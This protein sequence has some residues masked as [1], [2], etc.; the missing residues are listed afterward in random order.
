MKITERKERFEAS[1]HY[2]VSEN[3]IDGRCVV[4]D[5]SKKMD[6]NETN[7]RAAR[8]GEEKYLTK[9]FIKTFCLVFKNVV[10]SDWI[11]SGEGNMLTAD[12]QYDIIV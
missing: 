4:K 5:L 7:V 10:S 6:R 11:W 2:L 8:R 9:S 1:V 3:M 12:Q